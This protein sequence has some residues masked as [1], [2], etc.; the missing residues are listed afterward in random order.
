V[1]VQTDRREGLPAEARDGLP[2][3]FVG[4]DGA[5][6]ELER[7]MH[8]EPAGIL[9][10]GPS[11][12]GKT[13]LAR[14]FVERLAQAEGLG[15]GVAWFAFD[16]AHGAEHV[17][18][19]LALSIFG[20]DAL[21]A[22]LEAK[23]QAVAGALREQ[24]GVLVWDDLESV[25]GIPGASRGPSA[26][27]RACL[28]GLL[29]KLRGGPTKVLMT[30]RAEEE[31]LGGENRLRLEG[32]RGEERWE[33]CRAILG[34]RG[35]AADREDADLAALVDA[36]DGH[37]LAMGAVLPQ[38][39][40]RPAKAIL[41]ALRADLA[42]PEPA[43]GGAQRGLLAALRFV[44]QGV[45]E[46][47]RPLLLPLG[48]HQRFVDADDLESMARQVDA[49][50]SR[51]AIDR[52][53]QILC[54]A[55]L[56]RD[57]GRAIHEIHH[58][59][60]EFLA[61]AAGAGNDAW[62]RAFVDVVA[63]LA[64]GCAPMPL[65]E[66]R[67]IFLV[68]GATFHRA[69]ALADSLGLPAHA[70]ALTQALAFHAQNTRAL[71]AARSLHE[72]LA[73]RCER[74]ADEEGQGVAYRQLG[75]IA[76]DRG[77][78][79]GAERWYLRCLAIDE[80]LGDEHGAASLCHQLGGI[81]MSRRDLEGAEKWFLRSLALGEKL[82]D[83]RGAAETCHQRGGIAANR[84]DLDG[85]DGWYLRSLALAEKLGDEHGV[86]STCHQLGRVA[87]QRADLDGAERWYRRS[88]AVNEKLGDERGAA[89]T[90]HQL[91]RVA[92]QRADLDGAEKWYRR[93][94]AV[95]EK[96]DDEHGAAIGYGQLGILEGQRGAFEA[97]A[98]WLLKSMA[99]FVRT[100]DP[101]GA[102]R[103]AANYRFTHDA[104]PIALQPRLRQLWQE[105]G[106]GSLFE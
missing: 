101:L 88:L 70:A 95:N 75:A 105:A 24:R 5:L 54:L 79:D 20:T 83:E 57:R 38:L 11:G 48:L 67:G 64:D 65:D 102:Q 90:C 60:T 91:G 41:D 56:A 42:A 32:L 52:L 97:S 21:A 58:G 72:Q 43:G 59:L 23:L 51:A 99:A 82:G 33:L 96:L 26:V 1:K 98:A 80:K 78:L 39:E 18:N 63:R 85:A 61:S 69:V 29:E 47:L 7:A 8:A 77:D 16:V 68:H 19:D 71:Q 81:A 2:H 37:P 73:G 4:R 104:A 40:R 35:L 30:S 31:W 55:G 49:S 22:P 45:P 13:A 9:I 94:L 62:R 6:L 100:G 89:S 84:R 3:G 34:A 76:L 10:H 17:V 12:V 25:S 53:L 87:E 15:A 103:T 106:L 50:W 92:E 66:Q 44:E 46:E 74:L 86:A 93:S 36:L 14:A 27:D 28:K